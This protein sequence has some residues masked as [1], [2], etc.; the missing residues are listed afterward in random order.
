MNIPRVLID[1]YTFDTYLKSSKSLACSL[2][3]ITQLSHYDAQ[4]P[5]RIFNTSCL[6]LT[7]LGD[8]YWAGGRCIPR[9]LTNCERCGR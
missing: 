2:K 4:K 9:P 6:T 7:Y 3:A 1:L 5:Y 8:Q